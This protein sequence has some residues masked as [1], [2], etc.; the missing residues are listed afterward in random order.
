MPHH[1]REYKILIY[2][3]GHPVLSMEEH[4][5]FLAK[6]LQRNYQMKFTNEA[7]AYVSNYIK[8]ENYTIY[9][10]IIQLKNLPLSID[11]QLKTRFICLDV[12]F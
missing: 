9:K 8:V 10:S 3:S 12:F 6:I 4:D 5:A 11:R 7:I 1:A 2:L